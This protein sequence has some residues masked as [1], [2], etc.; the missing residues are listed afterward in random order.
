MATVLDEILAHK[1]VEVEAAKVRC[2]LDELRRLPGFAI[3]PRNFFGS[4]GVPRRRKPNLIAE[5]KSASPSAGRI[6]ADFDPVAIAARYA[7]GGADALS[8]LTDERFFG[9]HLR[10]I[11]QI[12]K[13]V[14]LPVLRKDFL[15]DPYQVFESRAGG[16]DAILLIVEALDD[17]LLARLAAQAIELDLAVLL[18]VHD[19]ESLTRV[20][21]LLD[22]HH[23]G[24]ILLGINN[25]DLR[26]QQVD[27]ATTERLAPLA[28]PGTPI[29]AESGVRSRGDVDRLRRAGARALLI[30][31]TLMRSADPAAMIESLFGVAEN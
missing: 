27:I 9:G 2:P 3:R 26:T 12:K 23:R 18:E 30:G 17:A 10:F 29:V 31:E 22:L 8:V 1:R 4:A 20:R 28:P 14:D 5:V 7:L 21:P 13:A 16:A 6:V 25:R 11:A 15:I 19:E 24:Q